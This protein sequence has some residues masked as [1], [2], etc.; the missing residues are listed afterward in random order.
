MFKGM[1]EFEFFIYQNQNVI[2]LEGMAGLVK[3]INQAYSEN[4][5]KWHTIPSTPVEIAQGVGY[6]TKR[7]N[8]YMNTSCSVLPISIFLKDKLK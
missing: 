6:A 5:I 4:Y 1:T 3:K 7:G 8:A 2:A